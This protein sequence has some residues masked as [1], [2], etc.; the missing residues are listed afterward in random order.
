MQQG[1]EQLPM[2]FNLNDAR[3][4]ECQNCGGKIFLPAY[5]F[6][7][8][9]RLLTGQPKDSV[10]PIELYVCASCG[11]PLNDLLPPELQETKITE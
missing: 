9:S 3:D 7:K 8:I 10:M 4:M 11:S 2:N 1:Q 6:K 5:R